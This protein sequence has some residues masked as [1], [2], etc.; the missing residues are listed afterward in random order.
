VTNP[1]K[2]RSKRTLRKKQ[3]AVKKEEVKAVKA[4][5]V[6]SS[7]VAKLQQRASK[8]DLVVIHN[9]LRQLQQQAGQSIQQLWKNDEELRD[10]NRAA[11]FNLRAHQKVLNAMMVDLSTMAAALELTLNLR[12]RD[13]KLP[14]GSIEPRIDWPYYHELVE[15]DLVELAEQE[16]QERLANEAAAEESAATPDISME[17]DQD[18]VDAAAA[19]LLEQTKIV[20]EEAGK[21]A[22]GEPYD[23]SVI[24]EAQRVIDEDE[25]K[26]G[27]DPILEAKEKQED[28]FPDGAAIFGG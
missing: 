6:K 10:G 1:E 5:K 22:R 19:E 4:E 24:D 12:I 25:A 21:M 26:H 17:N 18:E 20:A 2:R 27:A 15:Q 23:Q 8:S 14:D 3:L 13:A 16:K 9:S 7:P 11:E 28:Q